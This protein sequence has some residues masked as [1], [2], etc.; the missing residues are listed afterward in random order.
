MVTDAFR[1]MVLIFLATAT[2][3]VPLP[4]PDPPLCNSIHPASV[5]EVHAQ[6]VEA[7]TEK[8]SVPPPTP[9][10]RLAGL[11]SYEHGDHGVG[12]SRGLGGVGRVG[13]GGA[14][15]AGGVDV[16]SNE[17]GFDGSLAA[18]PPAPTAAMRTS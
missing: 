12:G 5:D 15:G 14:G 10:V 7:P 17:N 11:T 16:T 6:S 1:D 9:T 18:E 13:G 8:L 2:V 4:I 3:T